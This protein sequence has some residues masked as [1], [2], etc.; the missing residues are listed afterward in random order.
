ML[1]D[2]FYECGA[3][4]DDVAGRGVKHWFMSDD[5]YDV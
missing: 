5:F 3:A 4:F 1:T 2:V